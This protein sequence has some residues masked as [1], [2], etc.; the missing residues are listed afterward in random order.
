MRQRLGSVRCFPVVGRLRVDVDRHRKLHSRQC[1]LFHDVAH[2]RDD[3]LNVRFLA[4]LVIVVLVL[5]G[6]V[7][8]LHRHQEGRLTTRSLVQANNA[9]DAG[10]KSDLVAAKTIMVSAYAKNGSF[11]S[12]ITALKAAGFTPSA[13][14][15]EG[16]VVNWEMFNV[17]DKGF[18]LRGWADTP[19]DAADLWIDASGGVVGPIAVSDLA[20]RPDGCPK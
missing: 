15:T 10:V 5:A 19:G 13:K 11:P 6:A 3:K 1:R 2:Q 9:R 4:K 18:C 7:F 8:F 14:T 12:S 16:Y 17:S 20:S